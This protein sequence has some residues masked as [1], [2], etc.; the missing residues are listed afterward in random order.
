MYLN[1]IFKAGS[2]IFTSLVLLVSAGSCKILQPYR[3]PELPS[4]ETLFRDTLTADTANFATMPWQDL[5]T[6]HDLVSLIDEALRNNTDMLIAEARMKKAE[7]AL[8]QSKAA[9]YPSLNVSAG[10]SMPESGGS[11]ATADYQ[12]MG[13][14]S[15]ELDIWGRLRN[16][17]R[18]SLDLY[19]KSEAYK[20]AVQT[21]LVSDVANSYF[22]LLAL[23]AQLQITE[24]TVEYRSSD[25]RTIALMKE[26]DMVTG[27]DLVQS[28]A[29]LLSAELRIPDLKQN[30]YETE[31]ALST[32]VGRNPGLVKRGTLEDQNISFNLIPGIPAQLLSNRPDVQEAEYQLRY[33]YEMTNAARK[34]FYPSLTIAATGGYQANDISHIFDPSS[35]F[36]NIIGGLTQPLF[37]KGLNKQRLD[38][39]LAD[40]E[41]NVAAY[42]QVLQYSGEEVA[43]AI[44]GYHSSTEKIEMRAAQIDYLQKSVDY[45]MELLKYTSTTNYLDVLTSEVALLT[46]Q[47]SGV[48]DKLQQLQYIVSLYRSLGGGWR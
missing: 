24:K 32:L 43:D 28:Q 1:K 46:A 4:Q 27:A 2:V 35:A 3:Q 14:S 30:I 17:K 8:R 16:V 12:I 47:L 13:S 40:Q 5:F 18:A 33:G 15:W 6:D 45:T 9:L 25:V 48:D 31:N 11:G 42:R 23:D 26:N 39:A 36:W 29:N 19:L 38:A 20:R 7:A 22:T 10:A 41:E 34:Y 44:H 21:Q 37:N